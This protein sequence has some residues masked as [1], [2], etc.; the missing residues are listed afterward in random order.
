[1]VRKGALSPGRIVVVV[2]RN[3]K[4]LRG[5]GGLVHTLR[6]A[7]SATIVLRET[8]SLL[9]LRDVCA[10]LHEED[11]VVLAGGDGTLMAGLT[12]LAYARG[13]AFPSVAIVPGGT[14]CTV[15]RAYGVRGSPQVYT[16][17]LLSALARGTTKRRVVRPL[18]VK[19]EN[20][21]A[22]VGF[23]FGFGL[24]SS[25]FDAYYTGRPRDALGLGLAARIVAEVFAGSFVGGA[26]AGRVLTPQPAR[27]VVDGAP[28]SHAGYSLFVASVVRDLG[29]HMH[30]TYRAEER[31]DRF[32]AVGSALGPR[33]L[34]PQMPRV[35]AG[36]PLVGA[37]VD[38]LA[39]RVEVALPSDRRAYVLDGE[40]LS[41]A[42][43]DVSLAPEL[44]LLGL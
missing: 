12:A 23:I 4:R 19:D 6:R 9:D 7:R 39:S 34:G 35:L 40:L 13:R 24:V 21:E 38:A 27:L 14:V 25:F 43:V 5:E 17:R 20:G 44:V 18:L 26:L 16:E 22:R 3:A 37:G 41:S 10:S 32:H 2:N 28:Q 15:G 42:K 31:I 11:T 36:K 1:M 30:L 33:E 29:L 8:R